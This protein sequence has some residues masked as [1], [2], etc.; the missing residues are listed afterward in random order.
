TRPEAAAALRRI[1]DLAPVPIALVSNRSKTDVAALAS[2]LGVDLYQAGFAPEDTARFLRDCRERGI[3][4]AFLDHRRRQAM[5]AAEAHVATALGGDADADPDSAAAWLL[6]PRLDRF[7]DLWEIAR[8]HES[9][10]LDAQKLVLVPNVLCVAGAFLFG[11]TGL[12]AVMIT[13]LGTF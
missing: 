7:A 3:R 9:R 4:T 2:L 13:N 12:T 10:V 1:R 6:Q 8:T 5:A 11:F